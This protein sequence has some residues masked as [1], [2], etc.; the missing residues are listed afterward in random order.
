MQPQ[1]YNKLLVESDISDSS[2]ATDAVNR[3]SDTDHLDGGLQRK[4]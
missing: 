2:Y 1:F 3:R 4:C